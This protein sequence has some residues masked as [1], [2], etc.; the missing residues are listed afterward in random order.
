MT[1][2]SFIYRLGHLRYEF[3]SFDSVPLT[4]PVDLIIG[5]VVVLL[6]GTPRT[7]GAEFPLVPVDFLFSE[8]LSSFGT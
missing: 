1:S 5:I 3:R 7:L 2:E 4:L 8:M 6:F